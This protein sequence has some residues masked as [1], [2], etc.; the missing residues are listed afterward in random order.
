MS[1]D[2][3][4]IS[5]ESSGPPSLSQVDFFSG[6]E[7]KDYAISFRIMCRVLNHV[8]KDRIIGGCYNSKYIKR[9]DS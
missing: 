1:P 5:P 2:N 4:K 8:K 3:W 7:Q 6:G 9:G